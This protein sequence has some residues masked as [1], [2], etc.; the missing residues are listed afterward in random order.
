[1]LSFDNIVVKFEGAKFDNIVVDNW[2]CFRAHRTRTRTHTRAQ[3]Q[4]KLAPP[5][6]CPGG[7]ELQH[8]SGSRSFSRPLQHFLLP[9]PQ[10]PRKLT[11][12][13]TLNPPKPLNPKPCYNKE[14]LRNNILIQAKKR[15]RRARATSAQKSSHTEMAWSSTFTGARVRL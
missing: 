14:A 8:L 1:M 13:K 15:L 12:P 9:S 3:F 4:Q 6:C 7:P 5:A 10:A 2:R 11:N